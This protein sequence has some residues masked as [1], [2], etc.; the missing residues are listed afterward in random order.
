M[1]TRTPKT[2]SKFV[3]WYRYPVWLAAWYR[4]Q[5]APIGAELIT[6][7]LSRVA[8]LIVALGAAR[9]QRDPNPYFFT[10]GPARRFF[11]IRLSVRDPAPLEIIIK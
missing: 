7:A 2:T 1:A 10:P 11:L 8:P 3:F 9:M 6:V 4:Y 5:M